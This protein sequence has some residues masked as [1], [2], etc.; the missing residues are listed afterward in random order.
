[1][2]KR[3]TISRQTR[4]NWLI[5]VAVFVSAVITALSGG[6]FLFV[7]SDGYQGGRNAMHSVTILFAR[8]TWSDLHIWGGVLMTSAI[9]VH[10]AIHWAWV[11]R[12]SK[13]GLQL[14][15]GDSVRM[16]RGAKFNLAINAAVALSFLV[17]ALSGVYFLFAPH[18]GYQGGNNAVWDPGFL[19]SRTTWDL[20][21]TWS[22][23]LLIITAVVHFVIHWR[24]VKNVTKRFFLSLRTP[25]QERPVP[26]R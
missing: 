13:R 8:A 24:W 6:Y 1:M 4:T 7:P 20:L 15:R 21:H 19:W 10:V 5:D 14:L 9:I 12:M 25:Q 11:T 22:G 17:T 3:V 23:T 16:S 26:V 2:S 18:G